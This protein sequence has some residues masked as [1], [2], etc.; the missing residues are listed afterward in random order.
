MLTVISWNV[1]VRHNVGDVHMQLSEMIH[2]HNPDV[3]I[4]YEAKHLYGHLNGLGYHVS[5]LSD[6]NPAANHRKGNVTASSNV[7]IL[8]RHGLRRKGVFAIYMSQFWK[9]PHLGA[10]QDPRVYRWTKVVKDGEVWKIGGFHIPFGLQAR[11]ETISS[12]RRWFKLTRKGRP[13]IALGDFNLK[14]SIVKATIAGPVNAQVLGEGIDDAVYKDCN[15]LFFRSLGHH[16][17][18]HPAML[19]KFAKEN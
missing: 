6:K 9:G 18:D 5:Q 19:Y 14:R 4:L 3:I 1:F 7:A 2:E 13:T 15:C 8:T 10:P 11:S 17:S 12:I 16:G